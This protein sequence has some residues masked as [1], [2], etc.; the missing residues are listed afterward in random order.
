MKALTIIFALTLLSIDKLSAQTII[1]AKD[2]VNHTSEKVTIC[3][4]V[5]RERNKAF[6]VGLYLG[7]STHYAYVRIRFKYKFQKAIGPDYFNF[8]GKKICVTGVL[9]N[10]SYIKVDDPAQIKFD[11]ADKF[12]NSGS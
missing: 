4:R 2:A 10:G 8:E 1:T 12:E 6:Y 11:R 5:F 3:D 7:D 9:K